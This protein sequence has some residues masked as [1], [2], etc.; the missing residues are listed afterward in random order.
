M[1]YYNLVR[2]FCPVTDE[3]YV[4]GI[5]IELCNWLTRRNGSESGWLE[6]K[7]LPVRKWCSAYCIIII[8][9]AG[10]IL[11]NNGLSMNASKTKF[12]DI[13]VG[14]VTRIIKWKTLVLPTTSLPLSIEISCCSVWYMV[15]S[16]ISETIEYLPG[17]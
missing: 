10:V 11:K 2:H 1:Q 8:R 17:Y 12:E 14:W 4:C 6:S 9:V 16:N 3:V 5:I 13:F 7:L 15:H